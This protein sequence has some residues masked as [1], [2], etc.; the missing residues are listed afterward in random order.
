MFGTTR[1]AATL[2]RLEPLG[3]VCV[4]VAIVRRLIREH[5]WDSE[6]LT[7]RGSSPTRM[8]FLTIRHRDLD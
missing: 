3:T 4:L 7:K 1:S 5:V 2:F 8:S 6:T